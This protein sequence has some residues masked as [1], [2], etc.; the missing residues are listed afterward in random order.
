MCRGQDGPSDTD[1][2]SQNIG[3]SVHI[4][5][6]C[7]DTE[8]TNFPKIAQAYDKKGYFDVTGK[9]FEVTLSNGIGLPY[10]QV[11]GI[12]AP[13]RYIRGSGSS[14]EVWVP[15]ASMTLMIATD[16]TAKEFYMAADKI[17]RQMNHEGGY[18]L[19][20]NCQDFSL[21]L[22]KLLG[23][24]KK[25]VGWAE[26]H[27]MQALE[28][29]GANFLCGATPAAFSQHCKNTGWTIHYDHIP[30]ACSANTKFDVTRV[31][32]YYGDPN[33]CWADE[34]CIS[35]DSWCQF[36]YSGCEYCCNSFHDCW[37][38]ECTCWEVDKNNKS[39]PPK[40]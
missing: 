18:G 16:L 9:G 36:G 3:A 7:D 21:R 26:A 35:S 14:S 33:R 2:P 25:M 34:A 15:G 39:P 4:D 12:G 37:F 38:N 11:L 1:A 27:H 40:N 22:M 28:K 17:A 32:N 6:S 20:H 29:A 30:S 19:D 5:T 13:T 23:L 10:N 8:L 31:P 24:P